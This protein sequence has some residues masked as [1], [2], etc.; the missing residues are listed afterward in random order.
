RPIEDLLAALRRMGAPAHSLRS[1]GCPPLR[2]GGGTLPGGTVRLPGGKS[3]QYLTSLLLS[4]PCFKTGACIEILGDL[5]SKSYVDIT[6]DIMETFG[7]HVENAAYRRFSVAPGQSYKARTYRVE[8]DASSASYFLA[9]AAVTGGEVTVTNL[10]PQSV[11]GDLHFA[12]VLAEMGCAVRVGDGKITVRGNP[13]HGIT[14][15]MNDMPDT[16]PTLAVVAL[17]AS[18]ATTITGI[19]NLRIKETDR[20]GALASELTRL[21]TTVE[22]GDD[23]LKVTPGPLTGAAIETYH[24]HRMAMS[25]AVAGLRVPGVRIMNPRCVDKSFPEFF[26]RFMELY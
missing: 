19:G 25:F 26:T 4:A 10:N 13:L 16:A 24:D 7:V 8:G 12:D 3:S 6:L 23:Y 17:F 5:T 11:Q 9:A 20:I 2:V 1:N 15:S 21:G 22:A 14:V 18:G